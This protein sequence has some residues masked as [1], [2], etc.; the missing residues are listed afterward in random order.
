MASL[1]TA[2]PGLLLPV[3][4]AVFVGSLL[5]TRLMVWVNIPDIP[6]DRS[7]H[8]HATPRSG[9]LAV[10]AAVC[11]ALAAV[12]L[13]HGSPVGGT[14][15]LVP[16]AVIAF[17]VAIFFLV[18]DIRNL[19]PLVKLAGQLCA[20]LAFVTTAGNIDRLWLPGFGM[21]E[22]GP[23]GY[24]LTILWIV[25]F[26]NTFNFIDGV[27]GLAAGGA[28]IA[29]LF[30]GLIAYVSGAVLIFSC[31]LILFAGVL[32]FFVF[33]FPGGRIFLG[34]VG[35]QFLGF[36]FAC[37]AVLGAVAEPMR[38]SFYVVPILFFGFIFDATLTIFVRFARG[39]NI[40]T[41]HRDHL[42]QICHRLGVSPPRICAIHLGLFLINGA[43][44]MLA[45]W[46]APWQR[47]YLIL[48]LVP[49]HG[50]Y[51]TLVYRADARHGMLEAQG[52]AR[53]RKDFTT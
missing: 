2:L 44:A 20:A 28:L 8:T 17:L 22:F 33:N 13:V 32:G 30:L 42:F 25:G 52:R 35:S 37:L 51:A 31:C 12:G 15:P 10:A 7:A 47:L 40:F 36:I 14:H 29:A 6:N 41:P 46:G 21:L 1:T 5:L 50:A 3:G 23:W 49:L 16:T 24:P 38:I 34:D 9:G 11:P 26:M 48:L 18:D 53:S 27:H 45:Q 39:R 43:V 4:P 19:P